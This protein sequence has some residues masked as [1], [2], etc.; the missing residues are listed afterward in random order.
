MENTTENLCK[1]KLFCKEVSNKVNVPEPF[2]LSPTDTKLYLR[3][4][5]FPLLETKVFIDYFFGRQEKLIQQA[6]DS[7]TLLIS[8]PS[9][10]G[11]NFLTS[12]FAERIQSLTRCTFIHDIGIYAKHEVEAK[13]TK[14]LVTR[15]KNPIAYWVKLDH[16]FSVWRPNQSVVLIDDI[17]STGESVI[18]LGKQL[19]ALGI[20]IHGI[21]A[22]MPFSARYPSQEELHKFIINLA[23][24][25][26]LT[27][28]EVAALKPKIDVVFGEYL[29]KRLKRE[30]GSID[31]PE[32]ARK[33][34]QA[35]LTAFSQ[36]EGIVVNMKIE[37]QNWN[38]KN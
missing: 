38:N 37:K 25:A 26:A 16:L 34:Y 36:V 21:A 12:Y 24:N 8:V 5:E 4:R 31:T 2:G 20:P 11:I 9:T 32:R 19:T 3:E 35:I 7:N 28:S 17:I 18:N 1:F 33:C 27:T 23:K 10:S 6:V 13:S 15:V 14:K 30:K 22:L 29:Y